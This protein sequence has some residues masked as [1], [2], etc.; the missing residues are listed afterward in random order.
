M[1]ARIDTSATTEVEVRGEK[2][3]VRTMTARDSIKA[4]SL[5][6]DVNKILSGYGDEEQVT[7]AAFVEVHALQFSILELG[8]KGT[9]P[10]TIHPKLW[11]ELCAAILNANTLNEA[12]AKNSQ[13][14]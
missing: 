7:G 10:D 5:T 14:A 2:F 3:T 11:P 6:I 9:D 8:L 12:D 13:S 4:N 1:A